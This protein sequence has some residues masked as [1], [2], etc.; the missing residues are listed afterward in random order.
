[1]YKYFTAAFAALGASTAFAQAASAAS[2][3]VLASA[4]EVGFFA[5][6]I[7]F[8]AG[9]GILALSALA[10]L[11]IIAEHND[12]RGWSIFWL[13]LAAGVAYVTFSFSLVTL[14]VGAVAYIAIGL[15][16]SFWRYKRHA[17]KIVEKHRNSTASEKERAL[18][19]LHPKSMLGTITA[20]IVIWPFSMVENIVGDL[21]TAIQ[22]LV[23]TFFRGVYH[24][25]YDA[26]VASLK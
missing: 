12:S 2:G 23:T 8:I 13:L 4:A 14:L 3:P 21:I 18:R 16:W 17:A 7:G 24:R 11:G 25:V 19:D 26:A 9:W 6:L 10:L 15:V 1:M 20:W 22:S 5:G